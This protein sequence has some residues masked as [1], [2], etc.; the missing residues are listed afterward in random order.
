MQCERCSNEHDGSYASGRFCSSKCARG[1][2]TQNKRT[3]IS[4]KVSKR[5]QGDRRGFCK[6]C[7]KEYI[8]PDRWARRRCPRCPDGRWKFVPFEELKTDASRKL[9]LLQER[10]HR[11][12]RCK[13]TM[14]M[15]QPI[16]IELDHIDGHPEHNEK[17]NLRLICPN[18]HAQ[19]P[20]YRGAN[21][22]KHN[23]TKRQ[24]VMSRY[25][26]YR[27]RKATT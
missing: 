24:E 12:E 13:E 10:G 22:G 5:L 15:G 6:N 23:G 26:N 1:F 27:K 8:K 11:C 19:T 14:W 25:P 20:T 18:C 7:K 3:E 16:P 9:R 17:E 4:R 2:A 21:V